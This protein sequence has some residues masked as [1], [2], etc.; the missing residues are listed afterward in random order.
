[1]NETRI[2]ARFISDSRW[3]DIPQT[4]RHEAKRALLNGLGCAIGGCQDQTVDRALAALTPFS[5]PRNATLVGLR[6]KRDILNAALVN[7][8]SS[9]ILD[10]DDTHMKSIIHPTVPIAAAAW[11][12]AEHRAVTG[13]ELLHAFVLGV[14]AACRVGNSVSPEHYAAGWH[15][16]ATCGVFGAA[17][18]AG[19]LLGLNE[20]TMASAMGIAATQ[21]SGLTA[22]MGSMCKS[23]NMGHAASSGLTAALLAKGNFTSSD[24]ALEAPRGF[25]HVLTH[26]PRLEELTARLGETWELAWNAYKPYPCGIVLHA[27][28]DGCL[29]LREKYALTSER[30]QRI[31]IRMHPLALE[32]AGKAAPTTGLEGKLSVYHAAAIALIR[33]KAGVPEFSDKCVREAGVLALRGKVRATSDETLHEAAAIVRIE[34]QDGRCIECDVPHATGSLER[35]MSDA[36]LEAKFL[37][38]AGDRYPAAQA[39]EIV[40]LAWSLETLNDASTLIRATVPELETKENK[41]ALR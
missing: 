21:A 35:P 22:M 34:L 13:A 2:L 40:R 6:E 19:K 7:G 41:N 1:M 20:R 14:E 36:D 15:I 33:G 27:V 39:S 18:A 9:N 30:V 38:L 11:A 32:L 28:I 5:G 23:Y 26:E 29:E 16:T 24:Q 25:C 10:F 31:D 4:I 12:M 17:A 37:Q 3:S 8:L